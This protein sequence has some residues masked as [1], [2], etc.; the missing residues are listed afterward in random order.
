TGTWPQAEK[1][2]EMGFYLGFNGLIFKLDFDEIIK[3]TPLEKILLETDC[4]YLTPPP[5]TGRN[6]PIY[7]KY[8]AEKIAKIKNINYQEVEEQT[9][10]NA[11][12]LFRI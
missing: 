12:I 1:Y 3:K 10:K 7:L 11:K 2:L 8:I 4:P 5:M 9:T 6:E